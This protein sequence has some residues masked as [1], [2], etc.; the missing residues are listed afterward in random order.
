[1]KPIQ[2]LDV[3]RE[4]HGPHAGLRR[5]AGRVEKATVSLFSGLWKDVFPSSEVC[6]VL[7]EGSQRLFWDVISSGLVLDGLLTSP[8]T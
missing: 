1:M 2:H 7:L 4:L 5:E 3:P 6:P 8:R